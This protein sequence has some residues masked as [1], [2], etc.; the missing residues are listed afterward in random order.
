MAPASRHRR[1]E[2]VEKTRNRFF[3]SACVCVCVCCVRPPQCTRLACGGALT[4]LL[5]SLA[6]SLR[7]QQPPGPQDILDP[8]LHHTS[9]TP[10]L[11]QSPSNLFFLYC[12]MLKIHRQ[13]F[14]YTSPD[15]LVRGTR[16]LFT[17][18]PVRHTPGLSAGSALRICKP[19]EGAQAQFM[20]DLCK[21]RRVEAW[22]K[23]CP[24]TLLY[25][26]NYY[27]SVYRSY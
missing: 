14:G 6:L 9:S 8:S 18:W 17:G 26:Y 24:V 10:T 12:Y 21:A 19:I 11:S 22:R 16:P 1:R 5:L 25:D 3:V 2:I 23:R 7:Q 4:P 20:Q 15:T 13:H 27:Y